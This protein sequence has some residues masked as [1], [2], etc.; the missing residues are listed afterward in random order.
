[1]DF[2]PTGGAT[3][4]RVYKDA[5]GQPIGF[6]RF[7]YNTELQN[8]PYVNAGPGVV[9]FD[10]LDPAGKLNY[11]ALNGIPNN[12]APAAVSVLFL[13]NGDA[14]NAVGFTGTN[15][16]PVVYSTGQNMQY[17]SLDN[18][19]FVANGTPDDILGY[20]LVQLGQKGTR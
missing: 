10:P 14:A 1:M 4:I 5:W 7:G 20:R 12:Q 15:R 11:W 8:A 2:L 16:R 3:T 18:A 19:P 6:C 9:S 13:N 17:E